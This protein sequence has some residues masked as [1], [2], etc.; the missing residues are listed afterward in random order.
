LIED[1]DLVEKN[2]TRW[3]LRIFFAMYIG[4]AFF[5]FT[6]QSFP[7]AMAA[8]ESDLGLSKVDL[9]F[10][11]TTLLSVVY[12]VSKFASGILGDRSN[13][14]Y[15]MSI[16]L[17]IT[18]ILN[19]LFSFSTTWWVFALFW[20]L[21]GWFQG[22]GWPGCAKLL[23]SWYARSERGRWWSMW[24]T[25][26]NLGG[27]C[28]A[29][30]TPLLASAWGWRA[31]IW[32]PG[33]LAIIVGFFLMSSLR[34]TPESLG[35]PSIEVYK[36]EESQTLPSENEKG[37]SIFWDYV[38]C[39]RFVWLLAF[40]QFFIYVVR[41]AVNFWTIFYLMEVKHFSYI[42]AGFCVSWFEIGGLFGSLASGWLSDIVFQGKR[43][44]IN[45][46]FNLAILGLVVLLYRGVGSSMMSAACLL[47]SFGF[48]IFG[49]QMLIGMAAAEL[50]HKKAVATATG[51]TGCF[52]YLGAAVAGWPLAHVVSSYGW[53]GFVVIL[54]ACSAL[55]ALTLL[56]L[57]S[58]K[59]YPHRTSG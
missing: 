59:V 56:P 31:A 6:R 13:P 37:W 27:W 12:G 19:I 18:G 17:I 47:F 28:V 29:A 35:L 25:S 24:N 44:P 15:F 51:F 1:L 58:A 45:V 9:G 34:D 48:F 53:Q 11:S 41:T 55:G 43:N 50:S 54:F 16:G 21:N 3:R 26:H 52:S 33:V 5:Y 22:W 57:W 7:F 4:Y 2:Y 8:M 14:R 20:G 23:T 39:N 46:L 42:E 32:L 38:L 10:L 40:G 36:K 49:P 30:M